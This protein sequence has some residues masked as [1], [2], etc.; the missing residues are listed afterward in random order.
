MNQIL[1][2]PLFFK[3]GGSP[4]VNFGN[5]GGVSFGSGNIPTTSS[6]QNTGL[7]GPST[8]ANTA[9]TASNTGYAANV[10]QGN[11]SA[12][13]GYVP[14]QRLLNQ[15]SSLYTP[16]WLAELQVGVPNVSVDGK[17]LDITPIKD[18]TGFTIGYN[19]GSG[20]D[21]VIGNGLPN[22]VESLA[23]TRGFKDPQDMFQNNV[24][25]GIVSPQGFITVGPLMGARA[26]TGATP[27]ISGPYGGAFNPIE[28]QDPN[29]PAFNAWQNYSKTGVHPTLK[30]DELYEWVDNG[31]QAL[32]GEDRYSPVRTSMHTVRHPSRAAQKLR[33]DA[34]AEGL[35][36][37]SRN[38][39]GPINKYANG[40]EIM[41]DPNM[42]GG[43]PQGLDSLVEQVDPQMLAGA[44]QQAATEAESI[45]RD[46]LSSVMTGLDGA[47]DA[48]SVINALRG[49]QMPISARYEELA[50]IVG[51]QDAQ[52]TPESVLALV[53]P[54]IMLSQDE[55]PVDS[56]VGRLMQGVAGD[57]NMA[58]GE[59][60]VN[61]M[62]QGVGNLMMQGAAPQ[63]SFA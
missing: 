29:R 13:G 20:V 52:A 40:G 9:N 10:N 37:L 43:S 45:G 59:G 46:Y 38:N 1:N 56:G 41:Q 34:E 48:E 21:R 55:G 36:F 15:A 53:Q 33:T 62:G 7:F 31:E 3:D 4:E 17:Q 2:R 63:E 30:G 39:G 25:R 18:D 28:T 22:T 44:E 12:Y 42:M 54:S 57:V 27:K 26:Q 61:P 24:N 16:R 58:T 60:G 11:T 6:L 19:D 5:T 14:D 8:A 49:D 35:A 23:A 47:E 50:G 32:Y 51:L